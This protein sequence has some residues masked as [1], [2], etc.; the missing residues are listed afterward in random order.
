MPYE[1]FKEEI[2]EIESKWEGKTIQD[3]PYETLQT[4]AE[5][6]KMHRAYQGAARRRKERLG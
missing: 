2:V 4:Y 5:L 6:R 1:R 3:L